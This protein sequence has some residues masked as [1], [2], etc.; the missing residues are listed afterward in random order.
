MSIGGIKIQ[1]GNW[2]FEANQQGNVWVQYLP[3]GV[4]MSDLFMVTDNDE[5]TLLEPGPQFPVLHRFTW[6][7]E[8]EGADEMDEIERERAEWDLANS[9]M[10]ELEESAQDLAYEVSSWYPSWR[11]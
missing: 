8:I 7:V 6:G 1:N 2:L 9:L 5:F 11:D 10:R 3:T 4:E